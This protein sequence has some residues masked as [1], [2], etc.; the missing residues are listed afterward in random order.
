MGARLDEIFQL[1]RAELK[2]VGKDVMPPGGVVLTGGGAKMAGIEELAKEALQ[3]PAV[4]GSRRVLRGSWTVLMTQP[5]RRRLV[6]CL[7]I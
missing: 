4:V 2:K 1:V 6:L 5:T 3:L 7:R